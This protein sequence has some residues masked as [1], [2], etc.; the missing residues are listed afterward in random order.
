V[1]DRH[2]GDAGA[3]GGGGRPPS[4]GRSIINVTDLW[5]AIVILGIVGVLWYH[6]T[7][8]DPL[9]AFVQRGL[10]PSLFPRIWLGLMAVMALFL[11]FEQYLQGERGAALDKD[12][13]R[14]VKPIAYLT[15]LLMVPLCASME[16]LGSIAVVFLICIVLP[17]LW[18][19][20]RFRIIIPYAAIFPPAIYFLFKLAF[21][22][23][24]EPGVLGLG[25][26]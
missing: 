2:A 10:A 20:R 23:N 1:S 19:E 14:P 24:F 25:F 11:P 16:W 17:L 18:G 7:L 5:V 15:M 3:P 13:T 22:V 6:T 4:S 9:P 26:K 12:R 21:K 8:W